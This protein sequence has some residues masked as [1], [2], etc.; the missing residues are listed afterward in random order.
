M[1]DQI[2]R[3]SEN[4]QSPKTS[5]LLQRLTSSGEPFYITEGGKAKAVLLDINKYNAL[6][7]IVEEFESPK[8]F[9]MGDRTRKLTSV[10][11]ILR[12]S[13]TVPK[14]RRSPPPYPS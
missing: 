3:E 5:N 4:S 1:K 10:R 2:S 13:K 8:P 14:A 11:G 6:M 12:R 7:D 9:Q